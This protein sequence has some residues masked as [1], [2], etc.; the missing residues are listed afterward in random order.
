M[1]GVAKSLKL[2]LA[3][4]W[5]LEAFAQ[6]GTELDAATKAKLERGKRMVELLKQGQYQPMS[7]EDQVMMIFA[8]NEGYLDQIDAD[9]VA[10]FE[11]KFLAYVHS[12]HS[13]IP[14]SIAKSKKLDDATEK[15]LSGV[16]GD[17]VGHYQS[18]TSPDPRSAAKKEAKKDDKKDEA[19]SEKKDEAKS[20]KTDET[21]KDEKKD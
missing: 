19:K 17:F 21:K 15:N 3:S 4:Y 18:G 16:L 11:K 10:D 12:T 13:E 2:D 1:K 7:V 9:K 14:E 20:E 5:D 8:G 6:L